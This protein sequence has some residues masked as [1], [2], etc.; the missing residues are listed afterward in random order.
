MRILMLHNRY[1]VSGGED[2]AVTDDM[3]L[4]QENGH[5]VQLL[6][7]HNQEVD[8][9]GR[10]NTAV[11]TLWSHDSYRLVRE[12][13]ESG[14]FDILH[15]HNFFPLW[16]PSVY[17]AAARAGVPVVQ[18]LHNYRL[19]CV[20]AMLFRDGHICE[21]C[22]RKPFPWPGVM[23]GCYRE[24]RVGSTVVGSMTG[25]H[26]LLNTWSKQVQVYIAV[27]QFAREKYVAGGLAAEKIVVKPNCV[28]PSPQPGPGGGGYAL[29]V[30]R[31][32][33]EKGIATMLRAWDSA[34]Q[35]LPLKIVGDGPLTDQVKA[36]A[37]KNARL[38]YLGRKGGEQVLQLMR[39]AEF[40]VFPSELYETMGRTVLEALA[41][42]TP[43]VTS[44][45]GE[46]AAVVV[47][48]ETGFH[49]PAGDVMA[50][51]ER[52]EWCS[53][54]LPQVRS[55]RKAARRMFEQKFTGPQNLALL[56]SIYH[57]AQQQHR[58]ASMAAYKQ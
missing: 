6:E 18:T 42:G 36:S 19:M 39:E 37:Q 20:N 14:A 1:L 30:G 35:D 34:T 2:G 4:L 24:S 11:G 54:N 10:V 45:L 21:K 48:G 12:T 26:R 7:Q 15:V 28:H 53:Q 44:A 31:L 57:Q 25:L 52:V 29:Y 56:L 9:M 22:L 46:R 32:S 23:H 40:V 27:S 47:P 51:R 17:Y 8:R 41:V 33:A 58:Q 38:E 13:L 55:L 5:E 50:L 43:V 3:A 49:F 16:S